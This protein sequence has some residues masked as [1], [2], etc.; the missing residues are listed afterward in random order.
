M[1]GAGE[2]D[3]DGEIQ[4]P[5]IGQRGSLPILRSTQLGLEP[6][7]RTLK[8]GFL[9]HIGAA[10]TNSRPHPSLERPSPPKSFRTTIPADCRPLSSDAPDRGPVEL[11]ELTSRFGGWPPMQ[12]KIDNSPRVC[13]H[14]SMNKLDVDKNKISKTTRSRKQ[15]R[16]SEH[17]SRLPRDPAVSCVCLESRSAAVQCS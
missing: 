15:L 3:H 1:R 12:T 9:A 5:K 6:R 2:A 8:L 4:Y 11:P 13:R 14:G 10:G 7:R 17:V 16:I